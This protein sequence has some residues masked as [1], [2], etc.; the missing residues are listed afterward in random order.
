MLAALTRPLET[1]LYVNTVHRAIL[2]QVFPGVAAAPSAAAAGPAAYGAAPAARAA[3]PAAAPANVIHVH[4]DARGAPDPYSV[5]QA[6][7]ERLSAWGTVA[8]RWSPGR[9]VTP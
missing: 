4:V 9:R 1:T 8:G 7:S 2:G 6:I 3:A 5:G